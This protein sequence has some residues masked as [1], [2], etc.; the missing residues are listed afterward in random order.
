LKI[1]LAYDLKDS[2]E[3]EGRL[4]VEDAL[5]EYDSL[6]T[7]N[8]IAA[9]LEALG[10]ETLK[11]GG[12][13]EFLGRI[14]DVPVDFVFNIAEGRGIFR[15]RE[16]QVPSVLEMRG[17]PYSGSD[18]ACLCLCHDKP[19]AKRL[20]ASAGIITPR[21]RLI[22]SH[23]ELE[24]SDW[25]GFPLPAFLKP[26]YE[27]SSKG[28]RIASRVENVTGLK[29][30][31]AKLLETYLQPVLVEEFID[32]EEITVGLIGNVSS[33]IVGIMRVVPR[34]KTP[35]F[36]YSLEIK[37]DWEK[38]VDY[39]C[40]AHLEPALL[41]KIGKTSLAIFNILGCRD[42]ARL[43]MRISGQGEPYFLEINPL[44]GLNPR[45]S[46]YPIMAKLM[47]MSYNSLIAAIFTSAIERYPELK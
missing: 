3:K 28:V 26:A 9:A 40:P 15:S 42:F 30:S 21:W 10:Y 31:A 4:A 23:A 11:L 1:G 46:D 6:E 13:N 17:I 2:I 14:Q 27:G 8:A 41:E 16:A 39:E 35:F 19:L 38:L 34:Q 5:E 20:V 12:G 43:D 36:I 44:P 25:N 33:R 32:G 37:R 22:S 7:V 29:D 18:P 45:T 47:G 24:A